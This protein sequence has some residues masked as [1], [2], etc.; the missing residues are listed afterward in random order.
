[1]LVSYK[2]K[3]FANR[4]SLIRTTNYIL[5]DIVIYQNL[6]IFQNIRFHFSMTLRR[7]NIINIFAGKQNILKLN[8]NISLFNIH[9]TISDK[10]E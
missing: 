8:I 6:I 2:I 5:I 1:M 4:K 3:Y 10:N 9:T 7:E